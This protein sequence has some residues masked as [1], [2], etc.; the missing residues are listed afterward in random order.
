[1]A[2]Q[3]VEEVGEVRKAKEASQRYMY[4]RGVCCVASLVGAWGR[5][6]SQALGEWDADTGKDLET[7]LQRVA[8]G[9][10]WRCHQLM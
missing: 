1:M 4:L 9:A 2:R 3:S 10:G 7:N 8:W 5:P 6:S